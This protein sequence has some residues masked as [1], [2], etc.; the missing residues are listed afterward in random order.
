MSKFYLLA[1]TVISLTGCASKSS[2][3]T[4]SYVSPVT[5][6]SWTCR[7]LSEEAARLS[8]RAAIAA[9]IQDE[10]A[11]GDAW[12]TG[13]AIVLFWPAAF[14]INGDGVN[15][16]ELGRLKGEMDAVEQASIRKDCNIQ[17]SKTPPRQ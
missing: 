13:A 12:K 5:Y 3:I 4:A 10:K 17:F 2:D 6:E 16:G 7:Q 8:S 1:I 9:G 15:A 14:A 11:M